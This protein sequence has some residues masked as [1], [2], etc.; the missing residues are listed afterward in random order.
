R[1]AGCVVEPSAVET[2]VE[3][4]DQEV[5]GEGGLPLVPRR[6]RKSGPEIGAQVLPELR[7]LGAPERE[8]VEAAFLQRHAREQPR[9]RD[10]PLVGRLQGEERRQR[11][12]AAGQVAAVERLLRQALRQILAVPG[13]GTARRVFQEVEAFLRPL[14]PEEEL[15]AVLEDTEGARIPSGQRRPGRVRIG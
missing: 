4:L 3:R 13:G 11:A 1:G 2:Q 10:A 6:S 7:S 9:G 14:R 8:R 5:D 12:L 15:E